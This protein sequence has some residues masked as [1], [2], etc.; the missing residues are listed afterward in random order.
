MKT[1][2]SSR[3]TTWWAAT[4]WAWSG[5]PEDA[6]VLQERVAGW[7]TQGMSGIRLPDSAD[8]QPSPGQEFKGDGRWKVLVGTKDEGIKN[9]RALAR[10]TWHMAWLVA[11]RGN[12]H[13]EQLFQAALRHVAQSP[14]PETPLDMDWADHR[15]ASVAGARI[16]MAKAWL[17]IAGLSPDGPDWT[18]SWQRFVG[19][20]VDPA[21]QVRG[22]ML[23]ALANPSGLE[24]DLDGIS[25]RELQTHAPSQWPWIPWLMLLGAVDRLDTELQWGSGHAAWPGVEQWECPSALAQGIADGVTAHARDLRRRNAALPLNPQTDIPWEMDG[26]PAFIHGALGTLTVANHLSLSAGLRILAAR[27]VPLNGLTAKGQTVLDH[28]L[29]GNALGTAFVLLKAHARLGAELP[30]GEQN[31]RHPWARFFNE[32][33]HADPSYGE[34]WQKVEECLWQAR[35]ANPLSGW[36]L[37]QGLNLL[38]DAVAHPFAWRSA[39]ELAKDH[40]ALIPAQGLWTGGRMSGNTQSATFLKQSMWDLVA[41]NPHWP[42]SAKDALAQKV[43]RALDVRANTVWGVFDEKVEGLEDAKARVRPVSALVWATVHTPAALKEL[44]D[45]ST[46]AQLSQALE[47]A[48]KYPGWLDGDEKGTEVAKAAGID[49]SWGEH[50]SIWLQAV[51]SVDAVAAFEALAGHPQTRADRDSLQNQ[52]LPTQTSALEAA[53]W[54]AY[55]GRA[56]WEMLRTGGPPVTPVHSEALAAWCRPPRDLEALRKGLACLKATDQILNDETGETLLVRALDQR[57]SELVALLFSLGADMNPPL[58]NGQTLPGLVQEAGPTWEAMFAAEKARRMQEAL[59]P[60]SAARPRQR[61]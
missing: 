33:G 19:A 16:R 10:A 61:M 52:G 46:P 17:S 9:V 54:F 57:D 38:L 51:R 40:G 39:M 55:Y 60:P 26:P 15:A 59:P 56:V 34:P 42:Q 21:T 25:R 43:F 1:S 8:W 27:G 7:V 58:A 18:T 41:H 22:A 45:R 44:L 6:G 24:S 11:A 28:S 32:R 48:G 23:A 5:R 4:R 50:K 31:Q 37:D 2:L 47:N 13:T 29:E 3:L 53:M 12:A 30:N 20:G 36:T 14:L 35:G 49:R